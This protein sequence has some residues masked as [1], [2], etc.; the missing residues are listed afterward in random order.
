MQVMDWWR[1]DSFWRWSVPPGPCSICRMVSPEGNS[2][3]EILLGSEGIAEIRGVDGSDSGVH[4]EEAL[5]I[6]PRVVGMLVMFISP[7]LLSPWFSWFE[8]CICSPQL[9]SGVSCFFALCGFGEDLDKCQ[10]PLSHR[11]YQTCTPNKATGQQ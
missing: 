3:L 9:V 5:P 1:W 6:P 8:P 10:R 2:I 4:P 7:P 11:R